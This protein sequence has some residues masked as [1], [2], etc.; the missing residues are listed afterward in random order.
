MM[1]PLSALYDCPSMY[2][3]LTTVIN[4]KTHT[5]CALQSDELDDVQ[6]GEYAPL[7]R[8]ILKPDEI[9]S[10]HEASGGQF[11]TTPFLNLNKG[12]A[13][14][15]IA[16]KVEFLEEPRDVEIDGQQ[17]KF[18]QVD[19]K[20][21]VKAPPAKDGGNAKGADDKGV[22]QPG[23]YTLDAGKTV[24]HSKLDKHKPLTGKV[25]EIANVGKHPG[26]RY[27]DFYV[28]LVE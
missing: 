10:A 9:K 25:F 18:V 27:Y 22:Y 12:S 17:R 15:A 4:T 24:L 5:A 28:A 8:R 23:H 21:P 7:F 6:D 1:S 26:K 20:E 13:K 2:A 3:A 16:V 11:E 14:E 19:L